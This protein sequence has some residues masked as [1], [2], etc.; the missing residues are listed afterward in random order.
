[1]AKII[2]DGWHTVAGHYVYVEDGYVMR[3]LKGTEGVYQTAGFIYRR[4]KPS[5]WGKETA[6]SVAAFRAGVKRGTLTIM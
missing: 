4:L 2:S 3:G 6:V 1:M 5:G